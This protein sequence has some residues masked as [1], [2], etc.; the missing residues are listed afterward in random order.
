MMKPHF[1]WHTLIHTHK[2]TRYDPSGKDTTAVRGCVAMSVFV[3]C[4]LGQEDL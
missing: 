1:H 3:S 2:I 4:F